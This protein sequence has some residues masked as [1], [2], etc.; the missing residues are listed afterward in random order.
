M[1]WHDTMTTLFPAPPKE[2]NHAQIPRLENNPARPRA[3]RP[4]RLRRPRNVNDNTPL[5]LGS[6]APDFTL[7]DAHGSEI[8]LSQLTAKQPVV[9]IFYLG[10]S[11]PRCVEHLRALG[12][13]K[14]D[15]D[16]A[17]AQILAISPDSITDIKDSIQAFGDFPFPLLADPDMKT[18]RA[19][20]LLAGKDTL[21]HGT[22]VIDTHRRVRMAIKSSHPF[23]DREAILDCVRECVP[24]NAAGR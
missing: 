23:D 11:C 20:A 18:A 15:F 22:F 24:K 16:A 10:Y 13:R 3:R 14:P 8:T 9:L 12:D 19:Y 4:L 1:R 17:G 5:P 2:H 6:L 7:S 21:F